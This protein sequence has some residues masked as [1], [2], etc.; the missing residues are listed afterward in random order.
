MLQNLVEK[1]LPRLVIKF[2]YSTS[3]DEQFEWGVVGNI[4]ILTLIG[5]INSVQKELIEHVHMD[6][7]EEDVFVL[8][9]DKEDKRMWCFSNPDIPREPLIGMLEVIKSLLVGSRMAQ[10]AGAQQQSITPR[11]IGPSNKL[12]GPDGGPLRM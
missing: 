1:N 5:H 2:R 7:C 6:E 4:P 11:V 10:A 8:I 9:W 12:L 3:G